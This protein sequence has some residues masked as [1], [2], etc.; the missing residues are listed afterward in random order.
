M[1]RLLLV[2]TACAS[3]LIAADGDDFFESKIR[4]L[5]A[6]HCHACHTGGAL[7]NLRLDSREGVLK[8]GKSGRVVVEGKPEA[9]LLIEAVKRTHVR[10]KMP[11]VGALSP[12]EVAS[13]EEWVRMGLPWPEVKREV[14]A[15]AAKI[16]K[17]QK[18]FW[19]FRPLPA[20][21]ATPIDGFVNAK[22]KE[23]KIAPAR[24]ADA[25]TWLRRVTLS[26]TGL[27]PTPEEAEAF[28]K[29]PN[30]AAA[31]ERLLA[32]PRYGER[33][34][35]HW[36]DLARYSDGELAAS[37]DT[38]LPKAWRYR[39]WVIDALNRDLRFD[40]F[41]KA[42]I[43]ETEGAL[44]G[45][46]FQAL[47][48]GANDQ[49]D[50]TT[51][52]F[53][54]M[55]VGCAQCH[56]HKYDPIPTKDYYS[57]LGVFRSTKTVEHPLVGEAEVARY[58]AQKKKVDDLKE[59][60]TDYLAEQTKQLTDLLARDTAKYLVATVTGDAAGLDA[61]TLG[62]WKTYLADDNKEHAYLKGWY[63]LLKTKPTEAQVRAEAEKYQAFVLE[64]LD[65]A[66]EVD[67]KNYVAFGGRKGQKN[68]NTR[69]Y[70]NI[71]SLPVLKFYQWRE[72]AYKPYV[73]DGFKA[74]G[75]VYF[76][77]AKQ[78]DRFLGGIAKAYVEK[79]RAEIAAAEKE[80]PPVY[81]FLH[82]VKDGDKPADIPVAL[83]GDPK[84]PGEMAPRRFLQALCDDEPARFTEGSGR[85]QLAEAVIRHP[86]T[87][88]VI[89]N[90]VWQHHF[91]K[92]IVRTPSNFGRM[93][94]RPTHPELLDQLA[95]RFIAGGWSLKKLQREIVL[96]ETYGRA[97]A[98][99]GDADP[100][101]KLL[102]HFPL[103]HRL[104]MEAIR[105]SV[106]AVTGQLDLKAGG[107]PAEI[108]DE[109]KRRSVYLTVSRTRL[110]PAMAL[111]DFPDA[112]NTTDERAVTAGPLQGLYW[113][114]SAFVTRQA[115]VLVER[116]AKEAGASN[117]AR[118]QR[119][120]ALL[121]GRPADAS[122][123]KIGVEYVTSAGAN[124]WPKYLQA[125]LG[126]SEFSSV[127]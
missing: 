30:K 105:D 9:S 27:V 14:V 123:V 81:P 52:V 8:G 112:N 44:A 19:S 119:A 89:V 77:D 126:S 87:A 51:K 74:P 42:Q 4:P 83:R 12:Q 71:V 97:T 43:T 72:L 57:L 95:A 38:P 108:T 68:E 79:L 63:D 59:I 32:S 116:L 101:N 86:L 78:I 25:R 49:L 106:L 45:L 50:V 39:D 114:N 124:A 107:P 102:G 53:L 70:T 88:R 82:A 34:G 73:T 122:E 6:T 104:D 90:R 33:W 1:S 110:D 69:Q 103:L 75:G 47:G 96:S 76:Y 125:L 113:L 56:D 127:N 20:V 92:G 117:E 24:A 55:T 84:T 31:V 54:G 23:A 46:G 22:L 41:A 3:S 10:L 111:F 80:L 121:Y 99:S 94:E 109:N 118:I 40:V 120:Y 5:L 62:R 60:L 93:G 91:G 100:D 65:E 13:L 18:A 17:E 26:L 35:R 61:E 58:K 2:L 85:A 16:T 7:G 21:T 115:G 11:P 48:A 36:L 29:N 98:A 64:L 67:D 66:R 28:A 37:K 15:T